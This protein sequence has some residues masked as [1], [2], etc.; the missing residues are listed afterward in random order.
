MRILIFIFVICAFF[1]NSLAWSAPLPKDVV[2]AYKSYQSSLN[3]GDKKAALKYGY[4]AWQAAEKSLGDN[5]TTG[6]LAYNYGN[7]VIT[8][9]MYGN[10]KKDLSE[11]RKIHKKK[12]KALIRSVELSPYYDDDIAVDIEL[13]RRVRLA[14]HSLLLYVRHKNGLVPGGK[15]KFLNDLEKALDK[16]GK[17]GT[18]FEADMET[19]HAQ[20]FEL[21]SEYERALQHADLAINLYKNRIDNL[22]SQHQYLVKFYRADILKSMEKSIPSLLQYQKLMLDLKDILPAKHPFINRAFLQWINLRTLLEQDGRLEEAKTAGL[23]ECWPFNDYKN[24]I[25]P[26]KRIPPVMPRNAQRS[27]HVNL[28]FDVD[29]MGKP[30]NIK[31]LESSDNIFIKPALDSA[32]KWEYSAVSKENRDKTYENI[33]SRVTFMLSDRNGS[34]I[35]E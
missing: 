17:R 28:M 15:I 13:E 9:G 26:L 20:R 6:D 14:E 3:K 8:S 30:F 7:I 21:R 32:A 12:E 16:H 2:N 35:P 1:T 31:A 4:A 10:S 5:K 19:L 29:E 27:G 34:L 22:P 23:C 18:T 25:I 24:K 11:Q 33:V